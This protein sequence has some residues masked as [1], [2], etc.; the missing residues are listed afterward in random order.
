[1]RSP[2]RATRPE[3]AAAKSP[4]SSSVDRVPQGAG[5]DPA[6]RCG[7]LAASARR[8]TPLQRQ[9]ADPVP[10]P[11][12]GLS[13]KSRPYVDV[14]DAARRPRP[15]RLEGGG[16]PTA[17]GAELSAA[18]TAVIVGLGWPQKF[19]GAQGKGRPSAG[20][21]V[22]RSQSD[23]RRWSGKPGPLASARCGVFGVVLPRA[24]FVTLPALSGLPDGRDGS[25][26]ATLPAKP[27]C[28]PACVHVCEL[29]KSSAH[30]ICGGAS[31]SSWEWAQRASRELSDVTY[32]CLVYRTSTF[33]EG[34]S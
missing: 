8:Q 15:E 22:S 6:P 13:R 7:Q 17:P 3:R 29:K 5:P 9:G 21:L 12:G 4:R 20:A 24:P 19:S 14:T 30:N 32:Y 16:R 27:A 28:C 1:M 31:P 18:G 33:K 11:R 2:G 25:S 34:S 10:R 23:A 26:A